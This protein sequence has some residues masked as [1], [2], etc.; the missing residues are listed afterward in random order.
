[1]LL[2]PPLDIAGQ[3]HLFHFIVKTGGHLFDIVFFIIFGPVHQ[4]I[5]LIILI[6]QVIE[7]SDI[8]QFVFTQKIPSRAAMGA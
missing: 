2:V 8:L 3:L 7:E 5:D 6:R 1:M 4:G